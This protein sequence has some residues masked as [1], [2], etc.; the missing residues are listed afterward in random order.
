M[1]AHHCQSC[2]CEKALEIVLFYKRIAMLM[3]QEP[4]W[5]TISS[6]RPQINTT[7][8]TG[9]TFC[10]ITI[11]HSNSIESLATSYFHLCR[12]TC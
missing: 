2:E 8:A 6:Y 3:Y 11:N 4:S 7:Q 5:W 10:G 12:F 1:V 9:W